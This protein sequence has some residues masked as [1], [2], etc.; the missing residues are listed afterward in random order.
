MARTRQPSCKLLAQ[1]ADKLFPADEQP[2]P[3]C[4]L[5]HLARSD[6]KT[7][8]CGMTE[9]MKGRYINRPSLTDREV[10]LHRGVIV[11]GDSIPAGTVLKLVAGKASDRIW[12]RRL[13]GRATPKPFLV[14]KDAIDFGNTLV[15][16][17]VEGVVENVFAHAIQIG[18][19]LFPRRGKN[20]GTVVS[21]LI[22][23]EWVAEGDVASYTGKAVTR[24]RLPLWLA[25]EKGLGMKSDD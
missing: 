6:G 11:D 1:Q 4:V 20:G 18:K 2:L 14:A 12:C 15:E 24:L 23:G 17:D 8:Y 7:F 16:V 25:R 13:Q 21:L 10:K 5:C 22:D 3:E 9:R 19:L